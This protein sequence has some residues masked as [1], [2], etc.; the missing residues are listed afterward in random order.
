M[1]PLE[2]ITS[3]KVFKAM[4]ILLVLTSLVQGIVL[5]YLGLTQ[6]PDEVIFG[7]NDDILTGAWWL[8]SAVIWAFVYRHIVRHEATATQ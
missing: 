4:G 7:V 5:L 6:P 3:V 2:G 8:L 1:A